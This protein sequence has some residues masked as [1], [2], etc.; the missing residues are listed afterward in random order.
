MVSGTKGIRQ[1]DPLSLFFFTFF[2]DGL[3][4]T[5]RS[6]RGAIKGF[7]VGNDKFFFEIKVRG[8]CINE[9]LR[10]HRAYTK[11]FTSQLAYLQYHQNHPYYRVVT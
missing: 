9:V 5:R 7:V 1:G 6:A 3:K 11:I 8:I 10:E 2:V 4:R